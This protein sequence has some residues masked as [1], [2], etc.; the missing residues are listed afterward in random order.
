MLPVATPDELI[1]YYR[2]LWSG[3][4]FANP[5]LQYHADRLAKLDLGELRGLN[6]ACFCGV[7]P[8][9]PPAACCHAQ[10]LIELANP[11]MI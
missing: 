2:R 5:D 10:V 11:F 8:S 1:T 7:P 6:L 9:G 3:E 4:T